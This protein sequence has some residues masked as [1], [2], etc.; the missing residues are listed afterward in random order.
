MNPTTT[1][2]APVNA[3]ALPVYEPTRYVDF[4]QSE[5]RAAF[6]KALAQVRSELGREHPLVIGGERQNGDGTFESHNPA[7]PSEVVGRFQ[8][9][10]K[11]QAVKAIEAAQA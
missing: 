9:A 1:R 5:H 7:R 2:L 6:E 11:E 10:S 4:S 3:K 8:S